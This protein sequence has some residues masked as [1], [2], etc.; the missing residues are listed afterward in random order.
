MAVRDHPVGQR[1]HLGQSNLNQIRFE[2]GDSCPLDLSGCKRVRLPIQSSCA[3]SV[4]N[5]MSKI[6]VGNLP[7]SATE[8][9]VRELF[10]STAPSTQSP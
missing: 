9:T 3:F 8:T 4:S 6:Y 1:D 2:P 10:A 7:F 5:R